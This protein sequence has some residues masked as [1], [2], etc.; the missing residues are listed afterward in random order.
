MVTTRKK[1]MGRG[2]TRLGYPFELGIKG[3]LHCTRYVGKKLERIAII[4]DSES[5]PTICWSHI[6]YA[7]RRPPGHPGVF[8][9]GISTRT[10]K[11]LSLATSLD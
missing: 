1:R 2:S 3:Q 7:A 4:R 6:K 11:A 5:A 8:V 9:R 10:R